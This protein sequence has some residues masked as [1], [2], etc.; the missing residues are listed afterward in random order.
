M[1]M[2]RLDNF[3]FVTTTECGE[4]IYGVA[5]KMRLIWQEVKPVNLRVRQFSMTTASTISKHVYNG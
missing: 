1:F 3:I 5:R 4:Q 2:F